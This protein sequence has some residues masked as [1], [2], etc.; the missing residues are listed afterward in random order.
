MDEI[1]HITEAQS[2]QTP[3]RAR[4]RRADLHIAIEYGTG[5]LDLDVVR[6]AVEESIRSEAQ[7]KLYGSAPITSIAVRASLP[8]PHSSSATAVS[9]PGSE[10]RPRATR[11]A[12]SSSSLHAAS[13]PT[14]SKRARE[15]ASPL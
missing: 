7:M 5:T 1:D 15:P 3:H 8:P 4:H 12:P 2:R 10:T 14:K 9:M 6:R 13:S 11:T